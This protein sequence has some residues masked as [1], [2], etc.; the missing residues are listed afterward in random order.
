METTRLADARLGLRR[1][2]IRDLVLEASVGVFQ[3]EHEARQ[4]VRINVDLGVEDEGARARALSRAAVGR[5]VLSRVVDY[6]VLADA[7]RAIVAAGHVQL[8]ETMA[9]RIAERCLLDE[10]V[11]VARV[12]VEKIDVFPD[13]TSAG[14]EVE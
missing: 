5:D 7:I 11:R 14:V 4:R 1:M 8:I 10:R 2:F 12:T 3:R 9:E 6:G 13:A